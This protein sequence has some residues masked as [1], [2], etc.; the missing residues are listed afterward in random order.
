M[1]EDK[2]SQQPRRT[3]QVDEVFFLR[4]QEVMRY[5]KNHEHGGDWE[6]EV[7]S[8][9]SDSM[10]YMSED[11]RQLGNIELKEETKY[12]NRRQELFPTESLADGIGDAKSWE[13]E[14]SES[15]NR[16]RILFPDESFSDDEE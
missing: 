13:N 16:R 15:R 5:R 6:S 3:V 4:L 12:R 11:L 1:S 10:A 2:P 8:L 9:L 14:A 7:N